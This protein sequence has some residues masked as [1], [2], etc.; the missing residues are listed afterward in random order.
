QIAFAVPRDGVYLVRVFAFPAVPDSA[1]RFAGGDKFIYRLT[2][3]TGAFFDYAYPL[4]VPRSAPG[5]VELV[6]WNL[7]EALRTLDVPQPR[8]GNAAT[9]FHPECAN[10]VQV[11]LAAHGAI[12][13]D[14][15]NTAKLSRR[16]DLPITITG[17]LERAA[18]VDS[19]EF[20]GAKGQKLNFRAEAQSLGFPL[21]PVLRVTSKGKVLA[22]A[23]STA[24][25]KD[26]V[27]DFTVT[28]DGPH[29]LSVRDLHGQGSGRHVYRLE[30]QMQEP[31][32]VVK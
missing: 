9:L 25:G 11:R 7:P 31:D 30:A 8:G 18:D 29:V 20:V 5:K 10:A 24:I 26:P 3:T 4:A 27:L 22:K 15:K 12:A 2:L 19:Y 6:G 16:I 1:I 28:E 32:F 23:Q 17:R 14:T 21:D 13:N